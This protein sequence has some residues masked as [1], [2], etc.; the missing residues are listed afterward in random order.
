MYCVKC[1]TKIK[2]QFCSNCGAKVEEQVKNGQREFN[3]PKKTIY[4]KT[5]AIYGTNPNILVR[6]ENCTQLVEETKK[7]NEKGANSFLATASVIG[8]IIMFS[9]YLFAVLDGKKMTQAEG[10]PLPIVFLVLAMILIA[11][12][13]FSLHTKALR[14]IYNK[15]KEYCSTEVLLAGAHKIYGSTMESEF[16]LNY[17]QIESVR[18]SP[19]ASASSEGKQIISNDIFTIKDVAGNEFVFY[20]LSNCKELKTVIDMQMRNM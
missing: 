10:L 8:M 3:P 1:G 9:P 18:F 14:E 7:A 17:T 19:K 11:W 5:N 6:S 15:Y 13:A 12:V 4:S 16:E 2:G 20:S